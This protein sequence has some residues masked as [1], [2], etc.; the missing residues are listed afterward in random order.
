MNSISQ[1][2]ENS[3]LTG[4]EKIEKFSSLSKSYINFI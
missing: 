4:K 1:I 2:L 3:D